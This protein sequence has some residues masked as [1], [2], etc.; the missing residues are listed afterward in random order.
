MPWQITSSALLG[1]A[2]VLAVAVYG[3]SRL[4]IERERTLQKLLDRGAG[5]EELARAAGFG[6]PHR[7][8]LRRGLLLLGVGAAWT[9]V[10][11]FIGGPAW[12]LG[13]A[14]AAIGIVYLLLWAMNGRPR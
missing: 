13:G 4:R 7:A 8:D 14:P 3:Y 1:L 2:L 6:A 10:T 9:I 12:K 11:F 5:A